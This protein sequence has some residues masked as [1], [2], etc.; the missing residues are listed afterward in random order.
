MLPSKV[1]FVKLLSTLS[2]KILLCHNSLNYIT[3][4]QNQTITK[5]TINSF[6]SPCLTIPFFIKKC[7]TSIVIDEMKGWNP[8]NLQLYTKDIHMMTPPSLESDP[9][10]HVFLNLYPSSRRQTLAFQKKKKYPYSYLI[11]CHISFSIINSTL[12]VPPHKSPLGPPLC[13]WHNHRE[14]HTQVIPKSTISKIS[15]PTQVLYPKKV[16]I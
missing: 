7:S 12:K 14:S 10:N 5:F 6:T 3:C 8:Q 13:L 15:N 2:V 16:I 11:E 4:I 1:I 9:R